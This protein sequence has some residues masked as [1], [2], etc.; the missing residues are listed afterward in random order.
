MTKERDR[1]EEF[2]ALNLSRKKGR[3]YY[4]LYC[5]RGRSREKNRQK[6]R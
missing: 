3:K 2:R 5:G 4:Y 1:V 6:D